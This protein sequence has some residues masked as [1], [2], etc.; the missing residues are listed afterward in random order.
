MVDYSKKRRINQGKTKMNCYEN[1]FIT[2]QDL[3]NSQSEKLVGKYE[4]I[5]KNN[6]GKVLKIEEWGIRPLS[7][8]IKNNKKGF[9][10]HIKFEGTGKTIEELEKNENIDDTLIRFLTVRVKKHDLKTNYFEK[11]ETQ[12]L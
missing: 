3:T 9:Y 7:Y 5:I 4:N 8:Q 1:T 6:S 2:R 11:K 12:I 10:F